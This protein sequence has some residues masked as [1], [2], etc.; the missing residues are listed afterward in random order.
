MLYLIVTFRAG[1]VRREF[2]SFG[3]FMNVA[4]RLLYNQ[5]KYNSPS[6]PKLTDVSFVISF[7]KR[8]IVSYSNF[9][10][11]ARIIEENRRLNLSVS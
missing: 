5:L 6:H 7:S 3:T 9:C 1:S 2:L 10:F 11:V 4:I 8:K